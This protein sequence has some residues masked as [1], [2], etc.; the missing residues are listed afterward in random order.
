M[1]DNSGLKQKFLALQNLNDLASLLG[2]KSSSLRHYCHAKPYRTFLLAKKAGG[3]RAISA[4]TGALKTIQRR[5]AAILLEVYGT[6]APVHGF[7][8][9]RSIKTNA[10]S[11]VGRQY[12]FNLDLENFF[13]SIHYGRVQGMFTSKPYSLPQPVAKAIAQ[14]V[15]HSGSLPQGAPTSPIISNMICGGMDAKLK[16]LARQHQC[17]YTRYADDLTFSFNGDNFPADIS[18]PAGTGWLPGPELEA[19]IKAEG[20]S[21]NSSKNKMRRAGS[22]Q[23]VTGLIVNKRVNIAGAYVKAVRGMVGAIE[24]KGMQQA[25]ADFH[26]KYEEKQALTTTGKNF[27]KVLAGE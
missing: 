6:R 17:R 27:A 26:A 1:T 10:A 15:C 14:I 4:P 8:L 9:D 23:V 3:Y 21:I 19:T 13:P 12:V 7:A 11:H 20:F 18:T 24:K 16:L 25:E 2:V 22:R 5:L